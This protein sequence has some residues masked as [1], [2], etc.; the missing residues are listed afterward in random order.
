MKNMKV[1]FD[2]ESKYDKEYLAEFISVVE[3][4]NEIACRF[5][6]TQIPDVGDRITINK[7]SF[8]VSYRVFNFDTSSIQIFLNRPYNE[9]T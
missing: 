5:E 7:W 3:Y 1:V 4:M 8:S 6:F 2:L 9:N